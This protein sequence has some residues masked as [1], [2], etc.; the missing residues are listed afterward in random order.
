M[1]DN[2]YCGGKGGDGSNTIFELQIDT[3]YLLRLPLW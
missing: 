1:A 2:E 3:D